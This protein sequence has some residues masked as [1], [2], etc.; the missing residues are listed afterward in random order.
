MSHLRGLNRQEG[1]A[2]E[3]HEK[4]PPMTTT[5]AAPPIREAFAR[6]AAEWQ[7]LLT[8]YRRDGSPVGTPVHIAV[9]GDVAYVRTFEPSGKIKRIRRN[10]QVEIAPSTL[11]GRPTGT[12]SHAHAR[13]L[14]GEEADHAARALAE[15][16]P[17]LHG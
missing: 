16:Y 14:A 9:H 15:K 11:R 4:E 17:F 13:I 5:T 7:V 1:V 2:D 10:A 12:P 8:T 3:M 6:F